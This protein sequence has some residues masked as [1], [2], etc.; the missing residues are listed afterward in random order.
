MSVLGYIAQF[1]GLRS[2]HWS[3]T[4][5]Q[6]GVTLILTSIRA[7]VR[8]GLA[9]GPNATSALDLKG[10]DLAWT[11]LQVMSGIGPSP[12]SDVMKKSRRR[13]S[14]FYVRVFGCIRRAYR[15]VTRAS[16]LATSVERRGDHYSSISQHQFFWE[17]IS[18]YSEG[19]NDTSPSSQES[20]Q[21]PD[22]TFVNNQF[23]SRIRGPL[24][25]NLKWLL[26]SVAVSSDNTT[27]QAVD[28]L[29]CFSVNF[30]SYISQHFSRTKTADEVVEASKALCSAIER[31]MELFRRKSSITWKPQFLG[32][33]I[34]SGIH[35]ESH[36]LV[37]DLNVTE[38]D[39]E[40]YDHT[41]RTDKRFFFQLQKSGNR[42]SNLEQN[43][44]HFEAALS[45]STYSDAFRKS[46]VTNPTNS[47]GILGHPYQNK[48]FKRI[49]GYGKK[50]DELSQYSN[51][52]SKWLDQPVLQFDLTAAR[53]QSL[54]GRT[55]IEENSDSPLEPEGLLSAFLQGR[56]NREENS[57][58]PLEPE[59][60]L[61][62]FDATLRKEFPLVVI[63]QGLELMMSFITSSTEFWKRL[64][65]LYKLWRWRRNLGAEVR[66]DLRILTEMRTMENASAFLGMFLSSAS[67]YVFL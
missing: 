14:M 48:R 67:E 26:N 65:R 29:N 22:P 15:K 23:F 62:A 36:T 59:G 53:N 33:N 39:V 6:L 18:E 63:T 13:F 12:G 49:V 10:H 60:L 45:L 40:K 38:C 58:S 50:M 3:A 55:N 32:I 25:L 52:L 7:W 34:N 8:R 35:A 30:F 47:L 51:V 66:Q 57:D 24:S 1:V 28:P 37:W 54:Q 19:S 2:L 5:F 21:R 43:R 61:S 44:A 4:I 27:A 17:L 41:T 16:S 56:T 11:T 42:Y 64:T 31:S 46:R 20:E 9:S